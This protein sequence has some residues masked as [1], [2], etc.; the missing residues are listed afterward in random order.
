[1]CGGGGRAELTHPALVCED[2]NLRA[3]VMA[4]I[5]AYLVAFVLENYFILLKPEEDRKISK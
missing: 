5:A 4:L 3:H 1:M 2:E